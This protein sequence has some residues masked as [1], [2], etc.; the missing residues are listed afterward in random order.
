MSLIIR[1]Y[2]TSEMTT[3]TEA[4]QAPTQSAALAVAAVNVYMRR[5]TGNLDHLIHRHAAGQPGQSGLA[6]RHRIVSNKFD[7]AINAVPRSGQQYQ[8]DDRLDQPGHHAAHTGIRG[9][10]RCWLFRV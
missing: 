6:L 1:A 10:R 7:D 4:D 5:L 2:T 3:H 9:N 8:H